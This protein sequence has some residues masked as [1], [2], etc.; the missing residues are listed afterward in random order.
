MA[1]DDGF[2]SKNWVWV[3][4]ATFYSKGYVTDY[5][6]NGECKV[7]VIDG[8]HEHHQVVNSKQLENCNPQKFNK[9][10]DMAELTHLNEPSVVYNLYLRY[11][12]D[13]IYT[14]SGL[15]L[16]AINPY[17][18]LPIYD[19]STLDHYHSHGADT[20]PP[21]HIYATAEGTY[22]NLLANGKNQLILVTG[23]SGAGKTENTKKIIQY[24]SSITSADAAANSAID[25]KIL[26]ANP[27]LESFGNA[28]TIKN[29]NS[30][31]FGKFIKIYVSR[32]GSIVGANIEYY[33]LEKSRVAHQV[34]DERNY[35]VFYQFL[36]GASRDT[37]QE[38]YKLSADFGAHE[39]L[40]H[41]QHTIAKTDDAKDYKSLVDAFLIMGFQ[42]EETDYIFSMLA[43]V[44]HLGNLTFSSMKAEQASFTKESPTAIIAQLLGIYEKDLADNLLKPK[45]QAGREYI[46]KARKAPAVKF[47]VD[48]FA[49]Y[50]YE[51]VFQ[52][53]TK[54]INDNLREDEQY[55]DHQN[56]IGVLDIAGFEIFE[57]NSFEQLCINYTNEKLQQFFNHHSFILEQSEYLRED[58]QWEFIDFGQDL[59]PTID[60]IETKK[61][62]GILA[63]LDEECMVPKSSDKIFMEKLASHWGHGENKKFQQN[64]YKSGFIVHHYA[65][66]VEYN[67][68]NWLQKNTDPVSEGL[69]L[70]CQQ[71]SNSFVRELFENDEHL[72]TTSSGSK[73]TKGKL[74]TLSQK[75]KEQLSTL[76]EQLGKTEPHFVRCILPN[77]DKKPNKFD[78]RLVLHQLR[79]NGVLEGIRIA[80]AGYPNKMTFEEFYQRYSILDVK[81]VFTKN[82]KTNCELIIRHIN[83]DIDSYKVGISKLFFKN[84]VLGK[85]EEL[86]DVSLKALFTDFQSIV[87]GKS[88]RTH[89][90]SKIQQIQA[91]QLIARNF[92]TLHKSMQSNLWFDLFIKI[93]PL[94]ED[95]V[96][97]LDRKEINENL[98]N[99][100]LK[101]KETEEVKAK[102]EATN[103][104]LY[105]QMKRIEEEVNATNSI[106]QQR[107]SV[108]E[109]MQIEEE[110]RK[111]TLS[112]LSEQLDELRT[113]HT[114]VESEKAA[115]MAQKD[116]N[117]RRLQEHQDLLAE[118]EKKYLAANDKLQ[119]LNQQLQKYK[120]ESDN[121]KKVL[122]QLN[123]EASNSSKAM[124]SLKEEHEKRV[125]VIR[126]EVIVLQQL[127]DSVEKQATESEALYKQNKQAYEQ[128]LNESKKEIESLQKQIEQEHTSSTL[129]ERQLKENY[130]LLVDEHES[131][132]RD[133]S[134]IENKHESLSKEKEKLRQES[135]ELQSSYNSQITSLNSKL[136]MLQ[137]QLDESESSHQLAKQTSTER[138]TVIASLQSRISSL[139]EDLSKTKSTKLS[140]EGQILQL[141]DEIKSHKSV[142]SRLSAEHA[143]LELK[144]AGHSSKLEH[145]KEQERE[146]K[147]TLKVQQSKLEQLDKLK[148][149]L[150][151]VSSDKS[152]LSA[153]MA[154]SQADLESSKLAQ[155]QYAK[156]ILDLKEK[157]KILEHRE[158]EYSIERAN[159]ENQP[160]SNDPSFVSE[161]A[162]IK[163]KLNEQSAALRK[164]KFENQ[165]LTEEL[166]QLR[167]RVSS[168]SHRQLT[169][170]NRRS[171]A[172]GEDVSFMDHGE[173][174]SLKAQ[175]Q[176]EEL[177]TLRAENYA[178]EL[179]KKLNKLQTSRGINNSWN[180]DYEKK[181][182]ESQERVQE[183]ERKF[184][185]LLSIEDSPQRLSKSES[186]GRSALIN[187]TL[188][189][190]NQD[191]VKIYQDITKTLKVTRDELAASKSEILR[192]KR[193]LRELED[194]L[195]E[196]KKSSFKSSVTEYENELAQLK[197]RHDS[198]KTQN[199]DLATNV[200]VYRKRAAEYY[201][202]LELAESA[203]NISKRHEQQSA[204]ELES[205][206]T[207]L[208][209]AR[210]E[211]RASQILIKELK[212]EAGAL[213]TTINEKQ[214]L[215]KQLQG[216][217]GILNDKIEYFTKNYENVEN[218]QKLKD[219]II[220]L[221]KDLNFKLETETSLI[222]ENKQL[223]L[224]LEELTQAKAD[225][226]LEFES[227][228]SRLE[229]LE[230]SNEELIK[231]CRSLENDRQLNERKINNFTKQAKNLKDLIGDL[232]QQK[233]NLLADK[234][235]LEEDLL[236]QTH[237]SEDTLAKLQQTESDMAILRDHL[238]AQRQHSDVIRNEFQQSKL[239]TTH[240]VKDYL[241]LKK[242]ILVT[243]EEN[244]ALKRVNREL[245][246]K[247]RVLEDKL[248]GNEQ[249]KYWETKVDGLTRDLDKTQAENHEASQTINSLRREMKQLASRV[250]NESQLAKKYNDE[251]FNFQNQ[252]NHFKSTIDVLHS[253]NLEK[254]LVIKASERERN[255]MKENMLLLEKEV[256]QLR[257]RLGI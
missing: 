178:I 113:K 135:E 37:L 176:Q 253:E 125:Q 75:H 17:K 81:E 177:N 138:A 33:L 12:D 221:R 11:N 105:T 59:Q 212:K 40:K 126:D 158:S 124:Y 5:L 108:I 94:L 9:C 137:N 120:E 133:K 245:S 232:T 189:N 2:S 3:P 56:F 15:F 187:K 134:L 57:Q 44:L 235:R 53:I 31:R 114:E 171:L 77:L 229:E 242:E 233:D 123:E 243:G 248:Y 140:S 169:P 20:K 89:V 98:N 238:E 168:S 129:N 38:K 194:E 246:G 217:A 196:T 110:E 186:F 184:E 92:E 72:G 117:S 213:E 216:Q 215:V 118:A 6:P 156:Q 142:A 130:D 192:L 35:H 36:R 179:Q 164:E 115:L 237:T 116:E 223:S 43:V 70:L 16:V 208:N 58:I 86:R 250:A 97:V 106:V 29:N 234:D 240:D 64:K 224:D 175:L 74:K 160:P 207:Q 14:Y 147:S 121:Q 39:Y 63:I 65:G 107:D 99:V 76:M 191:F 172:F 252:V 206:R 145:Y 80:R 180:T 239:S 28:K 247:V 51:K 90:K 109:K 154:K 91:S 131:L 46:S 34:A 132:K 157:V 128:E 30:S 50:L 55:E 82:M 119:T 200:E 155:E 244:D 236:R 195:Y 83:L 241:K 225:L 251:N 22:R 159:K 41:S 100:T 101:L 150:M 202:K 222:K 18:Q 163:L 181:F 185:S 255:E 84:G 69:L 96:K 21:P 167:S 197:V 71:S 190:A 151:Q 254:D 153:M 60:L 49:K 226:D 149:E 4:D 85:L 13:M 165:K 1:E 205:T 230:I 257:D 148:T 7:T 249:L 198:V 228:S 24:L 103:V 210:E 231:K 161:F 102:L 162:S 93:K 79:C 199:A 204:A 136:E 218:Q 227:Q 143:D 256:L 214:Y 68:E 23:E 62:M 182:K 19:P 139:E 104:D 219:E 127:R 166:K 61:P 10:D 193:L 183:L 67:V 209:L 188:N 66:K 112:S 201:K 47:A 42:A 220:D 95:S 25:V 152:N 52:F 146:L 27:I 88:T 174:E 203:V 48:A 122:E 8:N 211:C 45:V 54:R 78:K 26:Q 141:Q 73:F 111:K 173:L 144:L 32:H 87:R 170:N